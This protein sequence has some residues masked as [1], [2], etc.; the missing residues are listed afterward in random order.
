[1]SKLNRYYRK[2]LN[3][4]DLERLISTLNI[5]KFSKTTAFTGC[6]E[7]IRGGGGD[8]DTSNVA[9]PDIVR[10]IGQLIY[11]V[12]QLETDTREGITYVRMNYSTGIS[13]DKNHLFVDRGKW[14]E[15]D[16]S[17]NSICSGDHYNQIRNNWG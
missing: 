7:K 14:G 17:M 15:N 5:I 2:A 9:G 10:I 16:F 11:P 6:T 3:T 13:I 1:M 8:F 4:G 12:G